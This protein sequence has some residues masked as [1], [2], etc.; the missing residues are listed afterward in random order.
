M[1]AEGDGRM[2]GIEEAFERLNRFVAQSMERART[3][4]LALA[5]T[6]RDGL[7]RVMTYGYA[8]MAARMAVRP[9]TLFEIGSVGKSFTALAVMQAV[10][11]G[12]LDLH[13]PITDYL[14]WFQVRSAYG[15]ITLHHLLSHTAGI[16]GGA[17]ITADSRYDAWALRDSE[18]GAPPG[19]HYHYSNLGY[20]VVGHV[21]E[22]VLGHSYREIIAMRILDPLGMK[23]SVPAITNDVRR[24]LAVGYD[25]RF[26]DRP[27]DR[28]DWLVPATWL[29]TATADGSVAATAGD[30]ASYLRLYLNRGAPLVREE[31]FE[32]MIQ[33]VISE[34]EPG[35]LELHYGYGLESAERD[36][37]RYIRHGGGMVGYASAIMADLTDGLAAVVLINGP[38]EGDYTYDVVRFALDLL[39]AAARDVD[40]PPVPPPFD[41]LVVE[42]AA[43]Y[44][45]NYASPD[46]PPLVLEAADNRL[47]L[48]H[49]DLSIPLERRGRDRFHAWLP[50]FSLFDLVFRRE[51]GA[52]TEVCRG[53]FAYTKNGPDRAS[54]EVPAEW[55]AYPGH[56]RSYNPWLSNFRVVLRR[57]QLVLIYPQGTEEPLTALGDGRFRVGEDERSPERLAFDTVLEGQALRANFSGC[58]YYR[59]FTP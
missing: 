15:P 10:E 29:E 18:T 44:A 41:P 58:E 11:E 40:L 30:M 56:Y 54:R 17:D 28:S 2:E 59:A 51:D 57:D 22:S 50:A 4:G 26:D 42:D 9:E 6:D 48:K 35:D 55:S 7:I 13:S 33:P 52:V 49:G 46:A 25:H 20:R 23:A 47:I 32:R 3:P 31:S 27:P 12:R 5:L 43:E 21:L 37:H 38:N 16:I 1:F 8:D 36:G 53:A 45:G 34:D 24:F 39:S 19:E 14:P